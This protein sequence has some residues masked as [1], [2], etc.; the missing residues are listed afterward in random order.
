MRRWL[1]IGE[2]GHVMDAGLLAGHRA[3]QRAR[4]AGTI[5]PL[6]QRRQA[7][8]RDDQL[9]HGAGASERLDRRVEQ[10]QRRLQLTV[11][12][13]QQAGVAGQEALEEAHA[14]LARA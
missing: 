14:V 7:G 4:D 12:G 1:E 6:E 11:R 13:V 3:E 5:E 8:Q 10:G 2:P 9:R